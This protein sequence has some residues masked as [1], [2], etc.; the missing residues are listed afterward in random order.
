[1]MKRYRYWFVVGTQH[2]YGSEIFD[3]IEARA[4]TMVEVFN[5]KVQPFADIEFKALLKTS[6]EITACFEAANH[7]PEVAGVMTWMHTFSPSKMWIKGLALMQ[8]PIL[9]LHTQFNA[10]IP[11][12]EIDMDFMN[13]NQ[14]AHGD[15]EHA[16][17]YTKMKKPRHVVSGHYEDPYVLEQIKHFTRVSAGIMESR[18]LNVIRFG[19][20]MRHVAVTEGDK[21]SASIQFGWHV[22]TY[23]VGD[24]ADELKKVTQNELREQLTKYDHRYT[25][26]TDQEDAVIYQAKLQVAIRKLLDRHNAK[27]FTTTFED[28][29]GLK[30]LPGLAAQDLMFEGYGFGAEGDWKTAA[31]LRIIKL[32]TNGEAKGSSFM[33]DYTYHFE[34]GEGF[35]LGAHMLEVCPS[36]AQETPRIEVHPLGIG[37]KEDPARLIFE[38]RQ[39]DAVQVSL[40]DL[41]DRFRLIVTDCEAITPFEKMPKLPVAC[42]M[43]RLKPNFS[44]ATEAWLYAGGA[45]HTVMSYDVDAQRLEMFAQFMGIE[46]VH[47]HQHTNLSDLKRQLGQ[48]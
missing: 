31:L 19:D 10:K 42:A 13:L 9:H 41:G 4:K 27:A 46:F 11:W 33:E 47:I 21:V 36:I 37:G 6:E 18:H 28:L 39:G 45:H 43:W 29:H 32:M 48:G 1:M 8:K 2:L 12:A 20:N 30:Q 14:S 22:N 3:I 44:V 17:L 34:K 23:P 24:L 16:H 7:D 26:H 15:R 38:G 40:I 25:H 35:V 5:Q